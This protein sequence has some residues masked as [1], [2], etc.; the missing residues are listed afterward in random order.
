MEPVFTSPLT[1][2][3]KEILKQLRTFYS[4]QKGRF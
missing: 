2:T 1:V 3:Q 4:L